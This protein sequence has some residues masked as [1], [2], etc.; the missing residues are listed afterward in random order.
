MEKMKVAMYYS[1]DNVKIEEQSVPKIGP[2]E[3][4]VQVKSSGIC[5]SDVMEWYRLKSAPRVLGH[6]ITGDIVKIGEDVADFSVGDKVF[7][8][9]HVP[10]NTCTYCLD[11]NHTLCETLHSTNFHPGGFAEYLKVP[12]INVDRGTF[13]LPDTITYDEGVFI[14]PLACV[15]RGLRKAGFEPGKSVLILGSGIAG[16]LHL[17]LTK[18]LG[19]TKVFTTDVEQF[20]LQTAKNMGADAVIQAQD[21]VPQKVKQHNDGKLPDFVVLCTGATAA[22]KQ[23]L[24]SVAP[25]G[26][27]LFFAPTQPKVDIPVHL[28]DLWNKQVKMTSTYAGAPKDIETAIN[29]L[30]SGIITVE[31]MI[32]HRLPLTKASKGFQLMANDPQ[33]IKVILKPHQ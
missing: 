30:S 6:E 13:L 26:T 1:N 33:A 10:C 19:A 25:G 2:K 3:L 11:D 18:A 24:Q 5:G 12:P 9:H 16:L 7:V 28:F 4:L 15:V 29:Y 22:A 20:K 8:S 23:A 14:E 21:D 31:D 17:K 32:T 27:I